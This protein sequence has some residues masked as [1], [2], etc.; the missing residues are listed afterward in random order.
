MGLIYKGG[1]VE[2][3]KSLL[4]FKGGR[5][6]IKVI[7]IFFIVLGVINWLFSE[8]GDGCIMGLLQIIIA[9]LIRYTC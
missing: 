7:W 8:D 2:F 9:L 5:K 4:F 3:T 1:L 6:M